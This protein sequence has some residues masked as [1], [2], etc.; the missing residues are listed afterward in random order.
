MRKRYDNT[1]FTVE[2]VRVLKLRAE[3]YTLEQIANMLGTSKSNIHSILKKAKETLERARNTIDLYKELYSTIS[4]KF[5]R[6]ETLANIITRIYDV[7]DIYGVKIKMR[8]LELLYYFREILWKC[9][10]P[11]KDVLLC[12][13]TVKIDKDGHVTIATR[14]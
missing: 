11:R 3:G 8:S 4:F 12:D 14:Q 5:N 10:E 13:I 2:Q 1:F 9:L 7:A 6:G